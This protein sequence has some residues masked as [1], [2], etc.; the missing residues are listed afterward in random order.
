VPMSCNNIPTRCKFAQG[1]WVLVGLL[2]VLLALSDLPEV[3]NHDAPGLYNEECPLARLAASPPG[4]STDRA[5]CAPLLGLAPH[6]PAVRPAAAWRGSSLDS[7]ESRAP[8]R[9]A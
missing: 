5:A 4:V 2:L 3:H 9:P 8:P 6:P 1:A 7:F